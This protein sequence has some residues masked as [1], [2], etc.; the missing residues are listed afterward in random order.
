MGSCFAARVGSAA[1]GEEPVNEAGSLQPGD[2]D[3]GPRAGAPR[4]PRAPARW[5]G[6]GGGR[7]GRPRGSLR[8][9]QGVSGNPHQGPPHPAAQEACVEAE[10]TLGREWTAARG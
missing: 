3:P 8:V 6:K 9:I 7:G 2:N 4:W 1:R 5:G 10:D